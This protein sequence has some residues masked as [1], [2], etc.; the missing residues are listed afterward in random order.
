M[1]IGARIDNEITAWDDIV[2]KITSAHTQYDS[3]IL[4]LESTFLFKWHQAHRE[5]LANNLLNHIAGERCV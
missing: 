5:K 1:G 3:F 2:V 4:V